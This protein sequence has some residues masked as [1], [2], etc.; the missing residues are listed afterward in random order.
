MFSN[1]TGTYKPTAHYPSSDSTL[2]FS[3]YIAAC[4]AIIEERRTDLRG[5]PEDIRRIVT[6][7]SPYELYPAHPVRSHR[8]LKSG[9]LLLH[10]LLD[11]P[12]S[13]RDIGNRLQ[14]QGILCRSIL[15]PGHG[16]QPA[17]L[18]HATYDDWIESTAYG[19]RSLQEEVDHVFLIGYSTGAALSI[20]HALLNQKIAG[21]ALI[22]PAIQLK[23][24]LHFL[25]NFYYTFRFGKDKQWLVKSKEND[26][27]KYR[28]IPYHAVYQVEALTAT[29]DALLEKNKLYTPTLVFMSEQDETVS[30]H[31][32]IDFFTKTKYQDN[33]FY[34]YTPHH[35]HFDDKRI[36]TRDT[37][38]SELGVEKFSHVSL[39]FA[40]NNFHYGEHGDYVRASHP[41]SHLY[42]YQ[43]YSRAWE[44]FYPMLKKMGLMKRIPRE[45]TYNPDFEFMAEKIVKFVLSLDA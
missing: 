5:H 30:A 26:Y 44:K 17:D 1:F 18:L 38:F 8:K 15:L 37:H 21:I 35:Q 19:I 33:Q 45:L 2:P 9:A 40:P 43:G 3:Q 29:N 28:S 14:Q 32:A 10:G 16:T 39:P 7:N 6:A 20:Y 41:H 27:T 24:Y 11:C 4:T 13:L 25:T 34:L 23:T 42:T 22:A 36:I 12:F 31:A